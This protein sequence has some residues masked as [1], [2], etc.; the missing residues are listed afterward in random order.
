LWYLPTAQVPLV[1][2]QHETL[3]GLLYAPCITAPNVSFTN[4]LDKWCSKPMDQ[5]LFPFITQVDVLSKAGITFLEED[6]NSSRVSSMGRLHLHSDNLGSNLMH[7]NETF[8]K[9]LPT[10]LPLSISAG[11]TSSFLQKTESFEPQYQQ[12][13]QQHL[14]KPATTYCK[15]SSQLQH[16]IIINIFYSFH[17]ANDTTSTSTSPTT[18]PSS[19]IVSWLI[20]A[21]LIVRSLCFYLSIFLSSS[22]IVDDDCD[23]RNSHSLL[24]DLD[25]DA[26]LTGNALSGAGDD[27]F[28]LCTE[29]ISFVPVSDSSNDFSFLYGIDDDDDD[30]IAGFNNDCDDEW[31][32]VADTDSLCY[33]I[34]NNDGDDDDLSSVF[35]LASTLP[36]F[37]RSTTRF[38][39]DDNDDDDSISVV[40]FE[41]STTVLFSAV[42]ESSTPQLRRSSRIAAMDRVCYKQFY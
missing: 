42:V 10:V 14:S 11:Q 19:H 6:T 1:D 36:R 28:V 31:N 41:S 12:L 29:T 24:N 2:L 7:V 17:L 22:E 5:H 13:Q 16:S 27:T 35:S 9:L 39:I 38:L 20:Y 37:E 25:D 33:S 15:N 3:G 26:E 4:C 32:N 23:D 30:D 40:S 34:D 8:Q 18:Q 21:L